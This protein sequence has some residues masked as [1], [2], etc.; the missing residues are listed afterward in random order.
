MKRINKAC[1]WE[2]RDFE[3][4]ANLSNVWRNGWKSTE[5]FS[6]SDTCSQKSMN[7]VYLHL[8][9]LQ[10]AV[11]QSRTYYHC[12][13]MKFQNLDPNTTYHIYQ[14]IIIPFFESKTSSIKISAVIYILFWIDTPCNSPHLSECSF[15][16]RKNKE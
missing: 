1:L 5:T 8:Y 16:R 12:K 7:C 10:I 4:V 6:T 15:Q 13:I 3:L 14:V 11:P 9:L 2:N